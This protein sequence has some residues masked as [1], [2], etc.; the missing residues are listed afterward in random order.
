MA[1][2]TVKLTF[3]IT[4]L[5]GQCRSGSDS[6][7][8]VTHLVIGWKAACGKEPGKRSAGWSEYNDHEITCPKCK[9]LAEV[10][11]ES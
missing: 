4:H 2:N 5:A 7:G 1:T 11:N 9:R 8:Y 10:A 6:R 3:R